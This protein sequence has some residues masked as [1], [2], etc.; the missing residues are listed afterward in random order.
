ML[1]MKRRSLIMDEKV[2]RTT[3]AKR[4]A[5]VGKTLPV[6]RSVTINEPHTLV[7]LKEEAVG[8]PKILNSMQE[9]TT[10]RT[11]GAAT[12]SSS[13]QRQLPIMTKLKPVPQPSPIRVAQKIDIPDEVVEAARIR[14]RAKETAT[15]T[16]TSA[17]E[18]S[19]PSKVSLVAIVFH[20]MHLAF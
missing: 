16:T 9:S 7:K 1:K 10:R 17:V 20:F 19:A 15:A 8:G 14:G 11:T 3:V 18:R 6:I 4:Q 12:K 5:A 13:T 2:L